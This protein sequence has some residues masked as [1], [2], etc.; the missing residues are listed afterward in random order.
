MGG[1]ETIKKLLAI[2]PNVKALVSS[3]YS[4]DPAMSNFRKY[5]FCGVITK[6]YN[7]E[8]LSKILYQ[9][10]CEKPETL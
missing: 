8:E 4:T 10:L 9:K 7:I 5:G 2:D 3:A 6:P 1:K